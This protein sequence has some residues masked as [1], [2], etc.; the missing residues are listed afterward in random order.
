MR[1]K[2]ATSYTATTT[3]CLLAALLIGSST[4]SAGSLSA[5]APNSSSSSSGSKNS[6]SAGQ[7]ESGTTTEGPATN[8]AAANS[9][10][11]GQAAVATQ[12]LS[13]V[14]QPE[15]KLAAAPVQDSSGQSI[16]QVASVQTGDR[17]AP[18]SV[19]VA[20]NASGGKVVSIGAD[21][22]RYDAAK[23]VVVAE[24]SQSQINALASGSASTAG[25][26]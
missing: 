17:G 15:R 1:T 4:A 16:G 7:N 20:L 19:Q 10:A 24:L 12:P 14:S 8:S 22:L 13:S 21:Q 2:I 6:N 18:T 5:G 23:N 9:I 25:T 26:R 3:A 11:G